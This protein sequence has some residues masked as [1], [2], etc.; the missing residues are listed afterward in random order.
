MWRR[1]PDN[2]TPEARRDL[3]ESLGAA[4]T[5]AEAHAVTLAFEPEHANVVDSAAAAR[6]LLDEVRSPQLRVV[7]DA[8]SLVAGGDP[9]RRPDVLREAFDLLGEEIVLAHAKDVRADGAIVPAGHGDLDYDL[10]LG[11]LSEAGGDV[12]LILHGLAEDEVAG[13]VAFL[14][15]SLARTAR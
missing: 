1:H 11:L 4:L 3:L 10:Y 5:L 12:P 9:D 7:L 15:D 6:R 13:C 14:R 8:A 2:R